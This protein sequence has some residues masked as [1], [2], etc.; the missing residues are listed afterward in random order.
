M[1]VAYTGSCSFNLTLGLPYTVGAALKKKFFLSNLIEI[2][3][4]T[5]ASPSREGTKAQWNKLH[6]PH[7][8]ALKAEY[9]HAGF[10]G[11]I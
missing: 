5:E 1:A 6:Q 8:G 9:G 11:L 4:T 7:T 2:N 10:I 3:H